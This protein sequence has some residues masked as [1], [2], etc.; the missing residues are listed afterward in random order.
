MVDVILVDEEDNQ[1]GLCE[2]LEAHEKA[3]LHRAFSIFIFNTQNELLLQK[4]ADDKYH[5]GGLWTNTCCSHPLPNEDTRVAA[6]RRL[7]E[8][9]GFDTELSKIFTTTYKAKLDKGLTEHEFLHVF[10]G[11]YDQEPTPNPEE[12]GDYKWITLKDLK[13]D[14]E[15]NPQNYTYWFKKILPEVYA[16]LGS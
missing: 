8:E 12:V 5:S 2:K 14:V 9:M 3:L 11:R 15:K 10:L 7:Q 16:N 6:H 1:I 4:R 13:S